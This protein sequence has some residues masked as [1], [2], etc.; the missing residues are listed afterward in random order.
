MPISREP[1]AT[2]AAVVDNPTFVLGDWLGD[3]EVPAVF[4][5][6]TTS[7]ARDIDA[8]G[9]LPRRSIERIESELRASP[10]F[11][12]VYENDDAVIFELAGRA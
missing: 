10:R 1:E 5:I 11:E 3:D 6:L 9:P 12:I 4:L 8:F 7:Q 2:R